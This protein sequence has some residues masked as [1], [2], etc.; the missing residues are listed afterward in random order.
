MG[1]CTGNCSNHVGLWTKQERFV[2]LGIKLFF[3]YKFCEENCV[4]LSTR[5]GHLVTWLQTENRL[6][7]GWRHFTTTTTDQP[8]FQVME[9][10]VCCSYLP[11]L[12]NG[13][14]L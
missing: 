4:V 7:A 2:P 14:W 3:I 9:S 5:I 1:S 12:V 11:N 8:R 10:M 13:S 6:F